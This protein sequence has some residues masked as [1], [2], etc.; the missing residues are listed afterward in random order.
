L[1]ISNLIETFWRY[2]WNHFFKFKWGIVGTLVWRW[3]E[4]G[5]LED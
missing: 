3:K 4:I 5:R 2:Y 1:F